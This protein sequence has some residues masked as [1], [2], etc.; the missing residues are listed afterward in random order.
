MIKVSSN[1]GRVVIESDSPCADTEH[2]LILSE[3][4]GILPAMRVCGID[5]VE[6]DDFSSLT[7]EFDK[8]YK[9]KTGKTQGYFIPTM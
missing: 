1:G 6:A 8:I 7:S 5:I 4:H 9:E 2:Y 3:W